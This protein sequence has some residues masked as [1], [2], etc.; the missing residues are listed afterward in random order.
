MKHN[1]NRFT[2]DKKKQLLPP[3][4]NISPYGFVFSFDN[5]QVKAPFVR[6]R[7]KFQGV[8]LNVLLSDTTICLFA[9]L[10]GILRQRLTRIEGKIL[11]KNIQTKHIDK[12][13]PL[14]DCKWLVISGHTSTCTS[15]RT[16]PS[17]GSLQHAGTDTTTKLDVMRKQ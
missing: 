17:N 14:I 15:I 13:S 3:I 4:T 2:I 12:F 9:F 11:K 10:T 8:C 7:N 6:T 5:Q 16:F 1:T